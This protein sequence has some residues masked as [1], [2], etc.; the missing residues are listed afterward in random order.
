V[1][2]TLASLIEYDIRTSESFG[3]F[4]GQ[5]IGA[6]DYIARKYNQVGVRYRIFE[7]DGECEVASIPFRTSMAWGPDQGDGPN[8]AEVWIPGAF[9]LK[10]G[11]SRGAQEDFQ[12]TGSPCIG[13]G[14]PNASFNVDYDETF[15]SED[16][17]PF[18]CSNQNVNTYTELDISGSYNTTLTYVSGAVLS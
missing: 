1:T 10:Y 8:G 6:G 2:V 17:Q 15:S 9:A 5:Q 18:G 3:C 7:R 14:W 16:E 12:S 11:T 13:Y 4:G